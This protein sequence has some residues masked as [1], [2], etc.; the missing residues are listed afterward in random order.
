MMAGVVVVFCCCGEREHSFS[1]SSMTICVGMGG[2]SGGGLFIL[3]F[4]SSTML[5]FRL[6]TLLLAITILAPQ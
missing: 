3:S 5:S 6:L 1:S 2:C 4:S